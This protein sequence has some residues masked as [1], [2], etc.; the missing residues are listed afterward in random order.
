MQLDKIHATVVTGFLGSGKTTLLSHLIANAGDKRIAVIV[1]EFGE[2]DID[3]ELLRGCPLDCDD[4]PGSESEDGVYE[5]ANG[6]ICCTVQEEFVPVM[7]KLIEKR[8]TIDH[9]VIETSG[10]ALPKPLV[11]AFNWPEIKQ[12]C[13]VDSVIAV[14]D[15]PAIAAGTW[16]ADPAAVDNARR[17]D[18]SLD[19]DPSLAELLDDQLA[20][21]D[22]AVVSKADQLDERA[23]TTVSTWLEARLP[24]TVKTLFVANGAV[25]AE[26]LTGLDA[27]TEQRIEAITTHHDAHH[28]AGE[29]HE[30]A[31]DHFDS[32]VITLGPVDGTRLQTALRQLI[33]EQTIYRVKGFVADGDKPMRQVVQGVGERISHYFD[34]L[35]TSD[36]QRQTR[37]VFIGHGLNVAR[38]REAVSATED[39]PATTDA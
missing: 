22:M 16:A 14:L 24:A 35:W 30:H 2:M 21:A 26:L 12:H 19:H 10:L 34:R 31:H 8:D 37:L 27:Q 4:A 23:R 20:A 33:S 25:D 6:C 36:E 11:Q 13:T 1:N 5:L 29:A 7:K 9:I 28:E 3:A 32:T 15:G 17:A 38:I 39:S 18:A